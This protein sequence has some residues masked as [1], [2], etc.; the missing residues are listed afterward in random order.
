ME[1]LEKAGDVMSDKIIYR[2]DDDISFRQCSLAKADSVSYGD[3]TNSYTF[4]ANWTT[5][6]RCNQDGIHFHCTKHPELELETSSNDYGE[7]IYKC[8]RC[9]KEIKVAN[10]HELKVNV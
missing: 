3:C 6:Y 9:Q 5:Y 8:P 2:I 4:E 7:Y 10:P 1:F